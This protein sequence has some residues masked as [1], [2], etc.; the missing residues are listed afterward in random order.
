MLQR[1]SLLPGV[2]I[3][4]ET[5]RT[6]VLVR[7]ADDRFWS[8]LGGTE[9]DVTAKGDKWAPPTFETPKLYSMH[10]ETHQ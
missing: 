1:G 8:L 4:V 2:M 7:L 3:V 6:W 9:S 10:D 5:F